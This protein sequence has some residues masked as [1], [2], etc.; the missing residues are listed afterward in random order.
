MPVECGHNVHVTVQ[1]GKKGKRLIIEVDLSAEGQP[2]K[3]GKSVVI[4]TTHGNKAVPDANVMLGI[5]VYRT[6]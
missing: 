3:T 2:S 6:A 1:N 4:A 5:N